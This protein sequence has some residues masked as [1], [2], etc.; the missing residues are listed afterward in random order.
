MRTAI[1]PIL[2]IVPA[3]LCVACAG[4]PPQATP[5]AAQ[6]AA[7]ERQ[8]TVIDAQLKAL[9]KA[10]KV[11]GTLEQDKKAMDKQLQDAGG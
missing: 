8:K 2:A 6:A 9:D 1:L 7:P 3:L 10:K 4:K 5:A 11:E